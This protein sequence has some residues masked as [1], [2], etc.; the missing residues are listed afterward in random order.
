MKRFFLFL[1]PTLL[2]GVSC[3]ESSDGGVYQSLDSGETWEQAVFVS[4]DGKRTETISEVDVVSMVFHPEDP[5]IIYLGTKANGLYIS[6]TGGERWIQSKVDSGNIRSIV[7][8]PVDPSNVYIAKDKSVQKSTDEGLTWE[9]VYTDV[10]GGSITVVAVDSFEHSRVYAATSTGTVLKS[11]DYGV[12]WD[13]RLQ[14]GDGIKQLLIAP[15]DTR[16]IYALTNDEELYRS[17]SAGEFTAAETADNIN[18]GWAELIT[19]EVKTEFDDIDKIFAMSL[20][21]N[22]SSIVYLVT[23]RGL[24]KGTNNGDDWQ[25][26]ITLL[27][28]SDKQNDGILNVASV[29]GKPNELYFTLGHVLHKSVDGG[30]TWKVIEDFP[31]SRTIQQLLIDPQTPNVMYAGMYKVEE[32]GGLLKAKN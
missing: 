19:K 24:M 2:L 15:H 3:S 25:D 23:R 20:D 12:N 17:L 22:D 29:P 7:V 4:S 14:L 32:E 28:V 30:V 31:S 11:F 18:S 9:T 6:L 8:D 10:Q 13:L 21:V 1:I 16:I 27:G 26:M 5:N